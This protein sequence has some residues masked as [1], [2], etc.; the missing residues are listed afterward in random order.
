MVVQQLLGV[1]EAGA[2]ADWQRLPISV[3]ETRLPSFRET[4][5]DGSG[6]GKLVPAGLAHG[7][8]R[9]KGWWGQ[10]G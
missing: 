5:L 2:G 7:F 6:P 1:G 3:V 9:K 10:A 8:L 4:S